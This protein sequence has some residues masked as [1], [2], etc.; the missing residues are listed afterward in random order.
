MKKAFL[1]L[2]LL[3]APFVYA[4]EAHTHKVNVC[5]TIEVTPG[6]N[7]LWEGLKDLF[8]PFIRS[9]E[10]QKAQQFVTLME[11]ALENVPAYCQRNNIP[12]NIGMSIDFEAPEEESKATAEDSQSE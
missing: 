3:A 12:G 11:Q 4:H 6:S 8:V 10:E 1:S 9:S 5:F 7:D 2:A